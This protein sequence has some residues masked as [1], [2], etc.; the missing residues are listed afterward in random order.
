MAYAA[1]CESFGAIVPAA[2]S[3]AR[4][5]WRVLDVTVQ[6]LH[7]LLVRRALVNCPGTG[8]LRCIP[9]QEEHLVR[10]EI[11][12]PAHRADEV[13]HRIMTCVPDGE[14][15]HLTLWR[16]HLQRHGLTHEPGL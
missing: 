4:L 13:M 1:Y 10:L 12:L 3:P 6:S 9:R 5:K 14:I 2:P 8:I 11:R 15:G 16:C 7:A